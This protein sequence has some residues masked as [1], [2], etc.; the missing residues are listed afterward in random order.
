MVMVLKMTQNTRPCPNCKRKVSMD[1]DVCPHCERQLPPPVEIFISYTREDESLRDEL[2]KHLSM[3]RREGLVR[4]WHDREIVAGTDWEKDLDE[5]L[6]QAK[7]ILLLVSS[8]FMA[9]DYCYGIEMERAMERYDGG[10]A[11]VIPIILRPV[12]WSTAPFHRIQ[13]LPRDA[14]PVT[15][16]ADRDE[17]FLAVARGIRNTI[18]FLQDKK[19]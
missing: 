18:K 10:E 5:H 16:W 19:S 4:L 7:I 6:E 1:A 14:K 3:M 11:V 2:I 8:S 9:S 17:A 12:D 15:R 13:A